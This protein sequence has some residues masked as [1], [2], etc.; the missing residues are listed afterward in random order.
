[1]RGDHSMN[2]EGRGAEWEYE[3]NHRQTRQN[4]LSE[5]F[6]LSGKPRA[7][8]QVLEL[9][10][11][12]TDVI[13]KITPIHRC[14]QITRLRKL[15]FTVSGTDKDGTCDTSLLSRHN[16]QRDRSRDIPKRACR[17]QVMLSSQDSSED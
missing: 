11:N 5:F 6:V 17:V 9:G 3:L 15:Y 2:V 4:G 16:V 7:G 10:W 13:L 12:V 1:M 14:T 8:G